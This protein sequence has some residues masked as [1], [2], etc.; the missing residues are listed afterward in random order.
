MSEF[1]V[2][3]TMCP[4][5]KERE[6]I[7]DHAIDRAALGVLIAVEHLDRV[8]V[9]R[10]AGA[11]RLIVARVEAAD[12]EV[13]DLG[14]DARMVHVDDRFGRARAHV[15]E[16]VLRPLAVHEHRALTDALEIVRQR[17]GAE[18]SPAVRRQL[19]ADDAGDVAPAPISSI[20]GA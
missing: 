12:V 1:P 19:V 11:R 17:P 10:E 9:E 3:V 14:V 13:A 6:P 4:C 18:V 5:C 20:T 16:E 7:V 8:E 15:G 2:A